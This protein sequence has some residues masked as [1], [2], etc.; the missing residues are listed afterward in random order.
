MTLFFP[1]FLFVALFLISKVKVLHDHHLQ[2][3]F[4]LGQMVS[5][6]FSRPRNRNFKSNSFSA[7][8]MTSSVTF[9]RFYSTECACGATQTCR[10]FEASS[11]LNDF[12][13][14]EPDN[15]EMQ[16]GDQI[17]NWPLVLDQRIISPWNSLFR[18]EC[19]KA[20]TH[21]IP[22]IYHDLTSIFFAEFRHWSHSVNC[23]L[24]TFFF[25]R[26]RHIFGSIERT[27]MLCF[28]SPWVRSER[29]ICFR[30]IQALRSQNFLLKNDKIL[31]W[32][33]LVVTP[34]RSL[35]SEKRILNTCLYRYNQNYLATPS[36][37][38]RERIRDIQ[39][40][41]PKQTQVRACAT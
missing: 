39:S 40:R 12:I 16:S 25:E 36:D 14:T 22:L 3:A 37:K 21:N 30:Q 8:S 26:R 2:S 41:T 34:N 7:S 35:H 24:T 13:T 4:C 19:R 27:K 28:F 18:T 33:Y 31:W 20:P 38:N 6:C 29:E 23:Q 10:K 15:A 32:Q 11:W 9:L 1:L 17:E 5:V